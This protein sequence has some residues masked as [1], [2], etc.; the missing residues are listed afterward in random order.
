MISKEIARKYKNWIKGNREKIIEI[1]DKIWRLAEIG[2][3]EYESSKLL[4]RSLE[5]AGFKVQLGVADLPT[6][7]IASFGVG[8]PVIA[9]LGEYDALPGL[10]QTTD[11]VKKPLELD[12]PGHGCGH[13][14]LGAGSLGGALAVKEAIDAG[15]AKGTIRFYGCPAE[16]KFN[17][18]GYMIKPGSTHMQVAF[19]AVDMCLYWCGYYG[20]GAC[21][22]HAPLMDHVKV[23]RVDI[24]GPVFMVRDIEMFQDNFP[25]DGTT[26]GTVRMDAAIDRMPASSPAIYPGD[27]IVFH[28]S[29]PTVGLGVEATGPGTGKASVYCYVTCLF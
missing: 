9:I 15:D 23:Y 14:L 29:E 18:K 5:E 17:S 6:A 24:G 27:S 1:S 22:S 16:E 8:K 26:T 21:H 19:A 4:A 12:A 25:E 3:V 13:N 7:L 10:S 20:T 11:P 28:V 2:L